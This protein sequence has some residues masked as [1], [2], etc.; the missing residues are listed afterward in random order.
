MSLRPS[1]APVQVFGLEVIEY[2]NL[3]PA[4]LNGEIREP[5]INSFELNNLIK[6]SAALRA[7]SRRLRT[8]SARLC[9]RSQQIRK[10][11]RKSRLRFPLR[12]RA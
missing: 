2:R 7:E 5:M 11:A 10:Q 8:E 6:K 9:E 4:N 12:E 1:G 3:I